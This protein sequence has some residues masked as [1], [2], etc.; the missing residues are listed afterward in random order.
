MRINWSKYHASIY[1]GIDFALLGM[2]VNIIF[3]QEFGVKTIIDWMG[4]GLL[5]GIGD[6][7]LF[8][9]GR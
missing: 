7:H 6:Y 3:W 4:A 1:S 5:F 9:K 8:R 2:I